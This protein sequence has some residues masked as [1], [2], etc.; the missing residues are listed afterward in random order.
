MSL[1]GLPPASEANG[2]MAW[3][4]H[5]IRDI[6]LALLLHFEILARQ[7]SS[8]AVG[9]LRRLDEIS[10]VQSAKYE[11]RNQSSCSIRTKYSSGLTLNAAS[12][13]NN[14]LSCWCVSSLSA[15]Y[16]EERRDQ[17]WHRR[18]WWYLCPL[19]SP[20]HGSRSCKRRRLVVVPNQMISE[21]YRLSCSRLK[22]QYLFILVT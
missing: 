15:C 22:A 4:G 5:V 3:C 6:W 18:V 2:E 16:Q 7:R 12:G 11:R 21:F 20:V 1:D 19:Y 14:T 8:I 17:G 9:R 10:I 13:K